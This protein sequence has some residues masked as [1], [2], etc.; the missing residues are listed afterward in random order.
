[1]RQL[2]RFD[3]SIEPEQV[4]K[5]P[6]NSY[7]VG[8]TDLN[9][10]PCIWAITEAGQGLTDRKFVIVAQDKEVSQRCNETNYIGNF[11]H[12]A[13]VG[14]HILHVFEIT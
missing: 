4:I 14:K 7:I 5:M 13:E 12:K 11:M 1:M 6:Y 3:L 9:N 2:K 10:V 8:L